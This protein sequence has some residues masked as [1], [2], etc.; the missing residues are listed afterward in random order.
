M[1]KNCSRIKENGFPDMR[2]IDLFAGCG[3]LSLGLSNAGWK[4]VFAIEKNEDA[5]ATLSYN[6]NRKP[7]LRF[8]W[9]EWLPQNAMSTSDLLSHYEVLNASLFGVPQPR[10][11]FILLA[12]RSDLL[13][14]ND[15]HTDPLEDIEKY[16]GSFR[17][18]K[19][20]NGHNITVR[21]AI[22]DLEI[23]SSGVRESRDTKGFQEIV[24]NSSAH[25]DFQRLMKKGVTEN[26]PA[27]SLRLAR[28]KVDTVKRFEEILETCPKGKSLPRHF[29]EKH[30]IKDIIG[31]GLIL[32][33]NIAIIELIKNSKDAASPCVKIH[34]KEKTSST[35]SELI[36]KDFGHG[37]SISDIRDKWLNIA[38]SEKKEANTERDTPFAGSKGV[39]RFS[40]DRL[41][42]KLTLYTRSEGGDYIK[43]PI[44]WALFETGAIDAEISTV[45]LNYEVLAEHEFLSEI[46]EQIFSSGTVLI[47][48]ELRSHWGQKKLRKLRSELEKFI[49]DPDANFEVALKIFNTPEEVI[50]NTVF[51]EL[52]LRTYNI[53]SSIDPTGAMLSTELRYHGETVYSYEVENPYI[54]LK[55]IKVSIHYMNFSSKL[56]FK[57]RTG[58]SANDY[59]SVFMFLNGFR[60]S[61]YG[62]P[63]NDWLGLDQRKTQGTS[64]Y[65]GTRDIVG[66]VSITDADDLFKPVTSREGLVH[67]DAYHE[68]TASEIDSKVSLR[69]NETDYGYVTHIVRQLERFIVDGVSWN[70]LMELSNPGRT[71]IPD[72]DV[73]ADPSNFGI[74]TI[75]ENAVKEAIDKT[76][77]TSK[78]N[79]QSFQINTDLIARL[80]QE[81][82][83]AYNEY[84]LSFIENT[85]DKTFEELTAVDKGNFKKIAL[86][87]ME[88]IKA[89]KAAR[90]EAHEQRLR[91]EK[92]ER[93][94][95]LE[96]E[97]A[98][99]AKKRE[100]DA[101][102]REA[103]ATA[104]RDAA[105]KQYQNEKTER[106]KVEA[107][108]QETADENMFLRMDATKDHDHVLN[109]HHQTS[110]YSSIAATELQNLKYVILDDDEFD[111]DEALDILASIEENIEKISKFANYATGGKYKVALKSV[112][113][114]V[115]QFVSEYLEELKKSPS[116]LRRMN[117]DNSLSGA[118]AFQAQFS[119]LDV[120]ILVDNL[121]SNAKRHGAKRIGFLPPC[122]EQGVF[123]VVDNGT[124]LDASISDPSEIFQKGFTT[125]T[126]GSGRGLYHVANTLKAMNLEICVAD[127][128]IDGWS[129]LALEIK[130]I[131]N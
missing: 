12:V 32:D 53:V 129:G 52:S 4:G 5:F 46:G 94:A 108:L 7:I 125:R 19:K 72:K 76:L 43:L 62:N 101:K 114:N 74:R 103:A 34:F 95:T 68:L 9:P 2:F 80:A 25:S 56:F 92:A 83:D 105:T 22:S 67:D 100:Q 85:T 45:K 82:E 30:G 121:I 122:T 124:G 1:K 107:R 49:S 81:A 64:R 38:Y 15:E 98:E 58:Y 75:D 116:E 8:D 73:K 26:R 18:L 84:V 97:R 104:A 23:G 35:P 37:M 48:S 78:F 21:E 16:A 17:K 130:E 113:G 86:R 28:H 123:C 55:N 54:L 93:Q 118:E 91:A 89:E 128:P 127:R 11:R 10:P 119:P 69:N 29:R 71:N 126:E 111:Q 120:M 3:G 112:S 13:S 88:A 36:L 90:L 50:K 102:A 6:F 14:K 41:G 99:Q 87:N 110:L 65:L 57:K 27:N 47:I 79:I 96:R 31:R 44:D 24:Y 42:K 109:L 131:A 39:G 115:T 70:S 63:K 33:D 51:D 59:G 117:V 66:Q 106:E 40:C 77:R 61:P 20:L 60:V